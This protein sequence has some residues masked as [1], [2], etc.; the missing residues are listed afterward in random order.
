MGKYVTLGVL[1]V[2][3]VLLVVFYVVPQWKKYNP[4]PTFQYMCTACQKPFESIEKTADTAQCPICQK[5]GAPT[6]TSLSAISG[7]PGMPVA[8]PA[9]N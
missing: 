1:L 9:G 5:K 3:L 4:P 7:A 8:P 2:V 6:I